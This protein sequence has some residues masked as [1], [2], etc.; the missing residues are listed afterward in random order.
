MIKGGTGSKMLCMHA[1][2]TAR[3]E[4]LPDDQK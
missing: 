3:L 2:T 1:W 4:Q